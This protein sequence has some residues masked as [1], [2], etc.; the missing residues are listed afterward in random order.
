MDA[1]LGVPIPNVLLQLKCSFGECFH[2]R[3]YAQNSP[4]SQREEIK[5]RRSLINIIIPPTYEL[6]DLFERLI[7][8][9]N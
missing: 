1:F 3:P 2:M 9:L 4:N 7:I 5:Y 8:L 6:K